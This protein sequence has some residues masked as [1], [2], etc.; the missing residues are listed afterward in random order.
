MPTLNRKNLIVLTLVLSIMT[1]WLAAQLASKSGPEIASAQGVN[2]RSEE[3]VNRLVLVSHGT[4]EET[5]D[6]HVID[7]TD[8][9]IVAEYTFPEFMKIRLTCM[10]DRIVVLPFTH[11]PT[12]EPFS[13]TITII[14]LVS[15][16]LVAETLVNFERGGLNYLWSCPP[17]DAN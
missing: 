17:V 12:S 16:S 3:V 1:L 15:G 10:K 6:M 2:D 5:S 9:S 4:D 7:T 11:V 14:D 8:G 13:G